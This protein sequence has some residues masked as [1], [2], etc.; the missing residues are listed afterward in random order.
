MDEIGHSPFSNPLA[1]PPHVSN[2]LFR[3]YFTCIH[4]IW[5]LIYKSLYDTQDYQ[6][7]MGELP[8]ALIFAIFSIAVSVQDKLDNEDARSFENINP[9]LFFEAAIRAL[10]G[11]DGDEH[12]NPVPQYVVRSSITHC[13]VFAILALQ[14]LGVA[15]FSQASILCGLASSIA[16]DLRLHR[17]ATSQTNRDLAEKEIKSRL[18]WTIYTLDQMLAC[19]M[20]RPPVLRYDD[21][22][23]P[24][25]SVEESDEYELYYR[26]PQDQSNSSSRIPLKLHTLSA[27]HAAI[28][29]AVVLEHISTQVYSLG[30]RER[31]RQNREFGEEIRL[32]LWLEIQEWE[33]S[34]QVS[35]LKLDLTDNFTSVPV[36]INN[37]VVSNP[38]EKSKSFT[39]IVSSSCGLPLSCF[40]AL[41]QHTGRVDLRVHSS[42]SPRPIHS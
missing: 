16:I 19:E 26:L 2:H 12:R 37:Y 35:P 33:T 38:S 28:K 30:N 13:Q 18:W 20:G 25:P 1:L 10:E 32:R 40:I 15:E 24:F 39:L 5:P 42:N 3:A 4:P 34:M 17:R 9:E 29:L 36:T 21:S 8:K 41:S 6:R 7:L 11:T 31:I 22:D 14:Q 27:F 23:A